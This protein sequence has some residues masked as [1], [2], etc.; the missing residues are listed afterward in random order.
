MVPMVLF[1]CLMTSDDLAMVK[2]PT[3]FWLCGYQ[4]VHMFLEFYNSC[5][6]LNVVF[7]NDKLA[8]NSMLFLLLASARVYLISNF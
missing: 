1:T 7:G 6:V 2:A 8:Y 3:R 5:T 4:S